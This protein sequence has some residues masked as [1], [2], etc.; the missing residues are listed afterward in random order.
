MEGG[1]A[2]REFFNEQFATPELERL[3]RWYFGREMM[4]K[5]GRDPAQFRYVEEGD[6]GGYFWNRFRYACTELPLSS[7]FYVELFLTAKLRDLRHGPRYLHPSNYDRLRALVDRVTVATDEV[8]RCVAAAPRHQFS[9]LNLS[10][11]FE[12]VSDDDADALFGALAKRIRPGG[13]IAYWNLLVPRT[14]PDTLANLLR[15]RDDIAHPLWRRD[16][17]WFYRSFHLE[18][19]LP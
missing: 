2:Q 16:R 15:R 8:E 14:S 1:S 7:N 10:D 5:Q 9:K 13:R 6:V 11:L 3:F 18:E 12:Y 4:E 19:V 17:S